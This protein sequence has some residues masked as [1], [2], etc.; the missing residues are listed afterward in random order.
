[1]QNSL[2]WDGLFNNSFYD[3]DL[4]GSVDKISYLNIGMKLKY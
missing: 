4:D 2:I 1:M 3:I